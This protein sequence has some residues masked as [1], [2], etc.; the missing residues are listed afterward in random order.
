M[1]EIIILNLRAISS[2]D[3]S[4]FTIQCNSQEKEE[5]E[6]ASNLYDIMKKRVSLLEIEEINNRKLKRFLENEIGALRMIYIFRVIDGSA[7]KM[8]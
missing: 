7:N 5:H 3:F 6:R 2:K 8:S 1:K 4:D